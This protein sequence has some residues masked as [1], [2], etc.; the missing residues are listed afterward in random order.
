MI[1][2]LLNNLSKVLYLDSDVV[3]NEDVL[4]TGAALHTYGAINW[5]KNHK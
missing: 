2:N 5:L 4:P 1:P 3:F